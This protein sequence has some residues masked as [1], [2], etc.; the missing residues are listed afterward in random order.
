MSK[1]WQKKAAND[2]KQGRLSTF[3]TPGFKRT[4]TTS[5]DKENNAATP[6]S[7]GEVRDDSDRITVKRKIS[8][9]GSQS[10][11]RTNTPDAAD[12]SKRRPGT[13]AMSSLAKRAATPNGT[14]S[15]TI[16]NEVVSRS[17][18][19]STRLSIVEEQNVAGEK[20]YS[21]TAREVTTQAAT[22]PPILQET[23]VTSPP[24]TSR[25]RA[26][27]VISFVTASDGLSST[28]STPTPDTAPTTV[29]KV[30]S[31]ENLQSLDESH[32]STK[33]PFMM[34]ASTSSLK[35]THPTETSACPRIDEQKPNKR[36]RSESTSPEELKG[37]Q[38]APLS[39]GSS[40]PIITT[41]EDVKPVLRQPSPRL[42]QT[43]PS[44]SFLLPPPF[45][46]SSI[47]LLSKTPTPPISVSLKRFESLKSSF[48]PY[49]VIPSSESDE[50]AESLEADVPDISDQQ[51]DDEDD[52]TVGVSSSTPIAAPTSLKEMLEGEDSPL[53]GLHSEASDYDSDA[54][55]GNLSD[56]I[57]GL[58]A[59]R[60]GI[61]QQPQSLDGAMSSPS[62]DDL[63][64][65]PNVSKKRG[66]NAVAAAISPDV[67]QRV[68]RS[69]DGSLK[70]TTYF[71]KMNKGTILTPTPQYR[72]SL[73]NLVQHHKREQ[74]ARAEIARAQEVLNRED[75]TRGSDS[76]RAG[77]YDDDQ[78]ELLSKVVNQEEGDDN[79][80]KLLMAM[81]RANAAK[82][83]TTYHFN[84][85]ELDIDAPI[86]EFP[87]VP[88]DK[89]WA[90]L[91]D[92]A[93]REDAFATGFA[94]QVLQTCTMDD[95]ERKWILEKAIR[96]SKAHLADNYIGVL[97]DSVDRQTTE[98]GGLWIRSA[99]SYLKSAVS[100]I[101]DIVQPIEHPIQSSP[102]KPSPQLL[103]VIHIMDLLSVSMP[104]HT[105]ILSFLILTQVAIDDE[106]M[107]DM[108]LRR[109]HHKALTSILSSIDEQANF[110]SN[111]AQDDLQDPATNILENRD[112]ILRSLCLSLYNKLDHTA[113]QDHLISNLPC[114][115]SRTHDFRRRLALAYFLHT[116]LPC[117]Q[118]TASLNS[119]WALQALPTMIVTE[120]E[121]DSDLQITETTD[122]SI[123][124]SRIQLLDAA[125]DCGFS[126][127]FPLPQSAPTQPR[128]PGAIDLTTLFPNKTIPINAVTG[129]DIKAARQDHN[130]SIDLLLRP[131]RRLS[132]KIVDTSAMG[133]M[134]KTDAKEAVERLVK[135]LEYAVRVGG[136]K[137]GRM[138][139]IWDEEVGAAAERKRESLDGWVAAVKIEGAENKKGKGVQFDLPPDDV[140]EEE[141]ATDVKEEQTEANLNT[142]VVDD[143][144]REERMAE[145]ARADDSFL[146][147]VTSEITG[148]VQDL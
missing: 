57:P 52:L 120:L 87:E 1:P 45:Q 107:Q 109:L 71:K 34:G 70:A 122:F 146:R 118:E 125:I 13:A 147:E 142:V 11:S 64:D 66:K 92:E 18:R 98:T 14:K 41:E 99:F 23:N 43:A 35:R 19:K 97:I 67:D 62:D 86:P 93:L 132:A 69:A 40:P 10:R 60:K 144:E 72:F 8:R 55:L 131:L 54:S 49:I 140:K 26:S 27:S 50:N 116:N 111:D 143:A 112:N 61:K 134:A 29:S 126:P 100:S 25:P 73:K 115:T 5:S 9:T 119:D 106:L 30:P 3:F 6:Q 113:L 42:T 124:T 110:A 101:G 104:I 12:V 48:P 129:T 83:R 114:S 32:P 137:G 51:S 84:N 78:N 128:P 117:R 75:D 17:P 7:S 37:T 39:I 90:L 103:R 88:E 85:Y 31:A 135:R 22:L 38:S 96:E 59:V 46:S 127:I 123:L 130:A 77:L 108:E 121:T 24:P 16:K 76:D 74:V 148:T 138:G 79:V 58:K 15:V 65:L 95:Q 145:E 94:R 33:E 44:S 136:K 82:T 4:T 81:S 36:I 89:A 102:R 139:G 20:E 47:S 133:N 105:K 141:T 68:T 21:D 28:H 56:I 53:S 2:T 63:D 80:D 91:K